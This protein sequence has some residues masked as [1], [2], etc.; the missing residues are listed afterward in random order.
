MS[1]IAQGSFDVT[2]TRQP[3]YDSADGLVLGRTSF[4]K[5]FKGPLE[6][7]S[8]V[9]MLSAGTPTKGS[10]VYV[11]LERVNGKLAG[12]TGNFVLVHYGIMNRG[13]PTLRLEVAPDSG[14]GELVGLTGQMQI[15]IKDGKHFYTFEYSFGA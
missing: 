9:E 4:V 3:P 13:T 1:E 14:T 15:D 8:T 2:A 6:A 5:S 10:A 11:A 12:R 7:S